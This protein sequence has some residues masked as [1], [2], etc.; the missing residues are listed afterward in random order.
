MPRCKRQESK[1]LPG[2]DLSMLLSILEQGPQRCFNAASPG[3]TRSRGVRCLGERCR[4]SSEPW[5]LLGRAP[6]Q[7]HGTGTNAPSLS[8]QRCSYST[9]SPTKRHLTTSR[10]G[11]TPGPLLPVPRV[12]WA[13][14]RLRVGTGEGIRAAGVVCRRCEPRSFPEG[15]WLMPSACLTAGLPTRTPEDRQRRFS[16]P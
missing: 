12:R 11:S 1:A 2:V 6:A 3:V 14:S 15:L 8:P 13:G 4:A 16:F 7:H 10:Y 5:A 9:M